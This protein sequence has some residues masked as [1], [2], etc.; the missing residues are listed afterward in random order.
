MKIW[1]NRINESRRTMI[2]V[3]ATEVWIGRDSSNTV[4]L[5]SPLVSRRHAVV[6]L[7]EDGRLQLENLGLNSCLVG[8]EEV[9]G[10]QTVVFTPGTKVRIWPFT[11]TFEAE[12]AVTVSRQELEAHLRSLI[13]DLE[14]RI[15]RK[16]LERLDLYEFENRR[17]NDP[18]SILLLENNIEDICRD[19]RVFEPENEPVLEEITGLVLR[20]YLVN[21]LIMES[22]SQSFY[23]MTG[24][25]ANEFDI[26]A[27]L[28]PEREAELAGILNFIRE[29]LRLSEC[30]DTTEQV[31]R[32]EEHFSEAFQLVRPHLHSELRK[33]LILRTL[34]KDLKDTIFGFGPLQDLLRAD[35]IT[36]IM[37]VGK[38]QIYV[39]RNGVIEKSG[40]R[41]IS[42]KVTEA[43]IERIVAQVGRR[44]DKSQPLVD[45]RLPDGSRVNAIIPPLA[46]KGPCLTIRKFP[47]QRMTMDDLIELGSITKAAATF[48]RAAVI[49]RKNILVSGGTGAGKTTLL[50]V[51][52][53]FI[54]FKER[55]ITIED[56]VELRL[57]QEHVVTLEAKPPNVEGQG[58][59]TIRDL[60][61]NALRMRPDRIIV[62]E[63]R[64]PEAL[65][66]IQAMNTGH[67]G[68]LTTL[69]A[70]TA[71]EVIERLEVLIL[72]AA[73]LPI[74][75]IHRQIASA[76]DLIVHISRLPGGRRVITEITEVVG[77]DPETKNV[78]M[79]DIFNF[80]NGQ[81]LEP[82][83][84]LPTFIDSL[85]EKDLLDLN[86]LYGE[87]YQSVQ[88]APGG[89]GPQH[90]AVGED[91]R[92]RV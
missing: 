40:R 37:V 43:I 32:I 88:A 52:S 12:K 7:L 39:E 65:D 75:S 18:Q 74:Y 30:R 25:S 28:V 54:P 11:L 4:V 41:F 8:E 19:L 70:N 92:V 77:V 50:N 66:M 55:I 34:K 33:Y 67:D 79:H 85:V 86:F 20:D 64:G 57:H 49:D 71:R 53:S 38:D 62:G 72:M 78:I 31:Q 56:T 47:L 24:L 76:I 84:Y 21:S 68:S 63:C 3:D 22:G 10:G 23:E 15:H 69:H 58:A 80:R 16:L 73:D 60:V 26:P 51:L 29:R 17:T 46:V 5:P 81:S 44:I 82:T 14:L 9:L 42:D 91:R 48:L 45:A 59:Y 61:R 83:G 27:T 6:R 89:T 90:E 1:Y 36:E 2:E 35:S 13:A 87:G